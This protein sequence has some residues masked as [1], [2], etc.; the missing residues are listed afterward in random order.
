MVS[1]MNNYFGSATG[2]T[3]MKSNFCITF[4]YLVSTDQPAINY[5]S[6]LR[7][8]LAQTL[9]SPKSSYAIPVRSIMYIWFCE[10]NKYE[11]NKQDTLSM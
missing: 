4:G 10:K 8:K 7:R 1:I 11:T 6:R 2:N 3:Y 5:K 9:I